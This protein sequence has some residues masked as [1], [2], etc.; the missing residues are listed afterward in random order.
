[1]RRMAAAPGK[2]QVKYDRLVREAEQMS[3]AEVVRA[4]DEAIKE[5]LIR[6][7]GELKTEDV[8]RAIRERRAFLRRL[9]TALDLQLLAKPL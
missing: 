7:R 2:V 9:P 1:M 8:L 5:V 4:C 6:G 3:F